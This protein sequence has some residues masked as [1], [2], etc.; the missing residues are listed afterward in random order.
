MKIPFDKNKALQFV[1]GIG[2][3][4][5]NRF[6]SFI[7]N[8]YNLTDKEYWYG[9]KEA[10][11]GC[12]NL[13]KHKDEVI[14]AFTNPHRKH[15]HYLMNNYERSYLKKLPEKIT[16]YRG[17]TIEEY[18]SGNFGISWTLDKSIADFYANKYLRNYTT[19]HLPKIVLTIQIEKSKILAYFSCRKEKEIIYIPK[20]I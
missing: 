19:N 3:D 18:K 2:I 7:I 1:Y 5:F 20:E 8:S 15:K 6:D 17:M 13:Y 16:I 9:L 4:S 11:T 14:K 12:D 10:Y